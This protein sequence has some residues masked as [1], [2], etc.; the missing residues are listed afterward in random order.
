M[1]RVGSS[2]L[3]A[4]SLLIPVMRLLPFEDPRVQSTMDRTLEQLTTNG[5]VYRYRTDDGLPGEEGAFLLCTFW[6]V[7]T[8]ALSGRLDEAERIFEDVVSRTNHLGLMSEQIDPQS[9]L[10]LGN[11]PQAFSHIGLITTSAYLNALRGH[12]VPGPLPRLRNGL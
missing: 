11:F 9:G 6:L 8:L 2:D 1:Q 4:S 10:F 7:D 3:D 12:H 5:L